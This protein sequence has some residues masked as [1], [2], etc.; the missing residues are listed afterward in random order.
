MNDPI[1]TAKQGVV[2][3]GEIIKAAGDNPNVKEAG[4]NLGQTALTITK[5]INNVMLPLAAVNF[6]FDKARIYFAERFPQELSAKASA[7]PA[8]Q[9][10]EPKASIAGPALQGLAFTHEETNL[11][12]MY[13]SLLATAMDGRVKAEAHPAFVEIIKQLDS[14]EAGLLQGL[15]REEVVGFAIVE[16]RITKN[17]AQG[18]NVL[19]KHI[20]NLTSP[21]TGE[22]WE[23]PRQGAMID[24][25]VRLGLAEVCYGT[26][27]LGGGKDAYAWV[28]MRPEYIRH[29]AREQIEPIKITFEPGVISRTALGVQFGRA[30][31]LLH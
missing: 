17:G 26:K 15:L 21:A 7:I 5:T 8:E 3:I 2:L 9:L 28:D 29:K 1:Q 16:I 22:P 13:L 4:E 6:A 14:E 18:W 10:V 25:W 31:G 20:M 24:N 27:R 23:S 11:K 12:E 30:V 19:E